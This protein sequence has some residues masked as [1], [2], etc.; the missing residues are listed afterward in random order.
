MRIAPL[1]SFDYELGYD[2]VANDPLASAAIAQSICAELGESALVE[3]PPVMGG[4]D[5]SAYGAVAPAAFFWVGSGNEA[6][7]TSWPHHHPRF[8]V[9]E[10]ALKDGIAVF[11][12]VLRST[13]SPSM[14]G[15][16][17]P[18][19]V[20]SEQAGISFRVHEYAH[21]REA[22]SYGL[23]AAE[24]LGVEPARVFKTL[25]RLTSAAGCW[26]RSCRWTSNST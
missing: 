23:E 13:C 4:E 17:T 14:A 5:F 26:S 20:A 10:G 18:A 22:P 16:S 11:V 8:D 6:L 24:K 2:P 21:D 1:Y 9:D 15:T 19:L 25:C 7:G 3:H 12:L